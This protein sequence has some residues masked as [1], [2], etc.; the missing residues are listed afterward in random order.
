MNHNE[1]SKI[2][3]KNERFSRFDE[4]EWWDQSLLKNA[5]ILVIGAGAIGNEVL[6]NLALL[7]VGNIIIVDMDKI[8]LSNLN[9]SVLFRENDNGKFKA[10]CALKSYKQIYPEAWGIAI[11]G[12]V[13]TDVG[14]G[15]FRWSHAVIGALDNREARVFVN[16]VCAQ[17]NRPWIDGGID[18]LNGI[19]RGFWP[20]KTSCYECTMSQMDWK[21]LNNR[22]SCSL[23]AKRAIKNNGVPTTPTIASIIGAIQAQE[24]VK[25]LHNKEALM[26]RG[27]FYNGESHDSYTI[28]HPINPSCRWH[29]IPA[30]IKVFPSLNS[31]NSIQ[32]LWDEAAKILNRVDAIDLNREF[33]RELRCPSC[34]QVKVV[35]QVADK[36]PHDSLICE[37]C[38]VE[39][40]PDFYHSILPEENIMD[41]RIEE[42]GL[43]PWDIVWARHED[44]YIGLEI[45]GDCPAEYPDDLK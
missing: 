26:G 37:K 27:Y 3:L 41:K 32:E 30:P 31:K 28:V 29:E 22:R 15:Y 16:K 34:Q 17:V 42:L 13:M 19:V 23:L 18:V 5:R 2:V 25:L 6:K 20:P 43:P 40:S 4:I 39:Y 38:D 45:S 24:L 12:N 1:E 44:Q 35:F 11:N 9:R 14:L 21:L 7:G 36:I 33:V 10:D 8:E